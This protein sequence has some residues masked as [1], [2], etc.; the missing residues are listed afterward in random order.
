M[1]EKSFNV[2]LFELGL[3]VLWM[4]YVLAIPTHYF[5]ILGPG[6]RVL[7]SMGIGLAPVWGSFYAIFLAVLCIQLFIRILA[8]RSGAQPWVKPLDIAAKVLGA[9]GVSLLAFAPQLL[10]ATN[11]TMG[12]QK[13]ADLN[14]GAILVFR[15]IFIL[16]VF[17]V[18]SD[19]W[20]YLR[21]PGRLR[22]RPLTA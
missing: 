3:H 10:I 16:S 17:G 11:A 1:K 15:L 2:R 18:F 9:V 5:L 12:S 21:Q 6:A 13:L 7:Q 19:L 4:L 22:R 14:H 8:L 20:K